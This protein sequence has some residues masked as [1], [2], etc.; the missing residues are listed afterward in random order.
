MKL[1]NWFWEGKKFR[2]ISLKVYSCK[3]IMDVEDI[4]VGDRISSVS[5]A[6]TSLFNFLWAANI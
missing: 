5:F 6:F 4:M 3:V 1:V 2:E